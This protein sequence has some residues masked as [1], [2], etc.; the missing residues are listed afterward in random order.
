M[1]VGLPVMSCQVIGGLLPVSP[2]T[3]GLPPDKDLVAQDSQL[4]LHLS[5][6]SPCIQE[7]HA[8]HLPLEAPT[9]PNSPLRD[10]QHRRAVSSGGCFCSEPALWK[11]ALEA[12]GALGLLGL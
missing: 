12:K 3:W 8:V 6:G 1:V 2:P 11:L 9:A 4:G 5:T 10:A 7:L